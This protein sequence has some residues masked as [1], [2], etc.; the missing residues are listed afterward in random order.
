MAIEFLNHIS[1]NDSQLQNA[2]IHVTSSAP[3]AATGQIYVDSSDS[4]KLK[5]HNGSSWQTLG[6][7]TGDI[8][9]VALTTDDSTT[10][11]DSTGSAAFTLAGGAGLRTTASSTTLT[12]DLDIDGMTDIGAGLASGDLFI[13]DDGAGGTNRKTTVDRIATLFAGSGLTAT[14][15]VIA[16]DTLNQDTTG[17]AATVTTAAQPA[18]TSLG[19]LTALQVDNINI[20]G[21]TISTDAGTDLNI[22]PLA[23]QQIVLDGTIVIDAGVVTGATSITSTAFVGDVTGDVSGSS[24]TCTGNA[25]TATAL[26]NARSFT[27]TGD[28]VLASANFDGSGNFTTTATIQANAVEGSMLNNNVISGQTA[29]TSG[30]ASTDE[31]A[32]SDAGTLKRMDV[33]VLQTYLQSNLTFTTNTDVSVSKDNLETTLALIDTNY[34]IGSGSSIDGTISGDLTINGDLIVSGT[35]TTINS[36]VVTVDD[37]IFTLGGDA[38]PGSDDNKDRGIEFRYHT[39]E[40]AAVG[41]FGYDDSLG[42]F[43]GYTAATNSSEVFSGTLMNAKF[44]TVTAALAG[45][46]TTAT[47]LATGRTIGMTGD[48]V[49]TSASFDGSGNVT[50]AATIQANA[51]EGSMLNTNAISGQ[52]NMTGDLADADELLVSDGG[53]LKRADFSVVRDAIYNDLSGDVTVADGGAATLAN[54]SVSQAQLDDDAVGA[55]ELAADAVVNA[56]VASGAAIATSKLSGALT[57]VT[58][59]GLATSATTDTTSASN[60]SSGTLA[61]ARLPALSAS[62]ALAHATTDVVGNNSGTDDTIFTVTHGYTSRAVN[63]QVY[64]TASPYQ[65][66]FTEVKW[67]STTTISVGFGTAVE[68]SDYTVVVTAD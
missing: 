27:T 67:P 64:Q 62:F 36:T 32:I 20:N 13:V 57:S 53:T 34:T 66:V 19:D 14:N 2:K 6:T 11:T 17:T 15:G 35:T 50:A 18:I 43:T 47:A 55:D 10:T 38:A 58:S 22:T 52:T 28:V 5:F 61:A 37:P 4:N 49:W 12:W 16:V 45:N 30:L 24:G 63:V 23:G 1:L 40:T 26:A 7:A 25:A 65:Q 59:H 60:I 46:A 29:L 56:S 44:G 42:L 39:G 21:N 8:T 51:V 48:V 41:F 3:T 68:Q 9:D 31:L 54:N 33:S